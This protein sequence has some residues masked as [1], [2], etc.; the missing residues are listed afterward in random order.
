VLPMRGWTVAALTALLIALAGTDAPAA[1]AART[2]LPRGFVGMNVTELTTRSPA[3]GRELALMRAS[4]VEAIRFPIYWSVAQPYAGAAEVPAAR[5]GR[6]VER[7]GLPTDLAS[8]DRL[9]AAAARHRLLV[10]PTVLAAPLWDRRYPTRPFSPPARSEPFAR[11]LAV[12]AERY[13]PSGTFWREHPR[14][15]RLPIRSWQVW[16]EEN[17]GLFWEDDDPAVVPSSRLQWV[18]PYLALL[19]ASHAALTAVDPGARIVLGGLVGESWHSLEALYRADPAAGRHFDVAAIHPYTQLP[20]NVGL[21][22]KYSRQ[23]MDAHG[24][25]AKPQVA[26]E[27]GWP[28]APPRARVLGF[29]TTEAGQAKLLASGLTLLTQFRATLRLRAVFWY[30]WASTDTGRNPFNYA[31]LRRGRGA[32]FASK[33]ALGALRRTA[34][35]LEACRRRRTGPACLVR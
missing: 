24:D 9:V 25:R 34:R 7:G 26:T 8:T 30:A 23:V 29:E 10:L 16:N 20:G 27:F 19:R 28:S 22:L 21:L 12:L 13:G 6:F 32:R 11:F 18:A 3:F 1:A 4:G 5:R 33:P 14:L 17:G 31:G 35:D 15:R 2:S